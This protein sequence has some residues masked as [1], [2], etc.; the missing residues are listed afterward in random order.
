MSETREV[1]DDESRQLRTAMAGC[2]RERLLLAGYPCTEAFTKLL[3]SFIGF[4]S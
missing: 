2:R 3:P 1:L 4:Q